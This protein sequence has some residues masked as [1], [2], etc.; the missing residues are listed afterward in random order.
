A[1]PGDCAYNRLHARFHPRVRDF[2]ESFGYYD[3]FLFD[4]DGNLVYSVFK[5]TD[6]ATNFLSGAYRDTKFA[7]VFRL[8][9]EATAPGEVLIRDFEPYDPSYGAPA[10]FIGSPVFRGHEKIGVAVFQMPVDQINDIMA[11]VSGLGETGETYL[12]GDDHLMR[13]DSRFAA[14]STILVQ[15]IDTE[16]SK[17]ALSGESGM[18]QQRDYRGIDVL[19]SYGPLQIAGLDWAMLAEVDMAEITAPAVALRNRIVAI[20]VGLAVV[21]GILT[22]FFLNRIVINPVRKLAEGTRRVERGEYTTRVH[23]GSTDE[24]GELAL[25]FNHMTASIRRDTDA[26]RKLTRAVEQSSSIVLITDPQGQIE[27]VNPKFTEVTGYT[28]QEAIG[29]NPRMLKSGKH[30]P[31]VYA[32]LWGALTSGREFHGEFQ[33]RKKDGS[34]YW[35]SVSMSPIRGVDATTT[36]FLA[37]QDDITDRKAA[38]EELHRA[39]AEA[40]AANRAKSQFLANMSHE[41]RTP[42]NAIIGYSEMLAEEAED[43]GEDALIS[44][45]NKIHGAGKHLLTLINEI[46]DLSKIE[47][48]KMELFLEE[49]DVAEMVNEVIATVTPL[50][51]KNANTLETN[52]AEDAGQ[53]RADLTKIRQSL[54]NLISNAS[55]FT[56]EGTIRVEVQRAPDNGHLMFKVADSG[57]GMNEQQLGKLFQAFS[58]ADASTTRKYGGTGLGLVIT[59]RFCDMMGGSIDV[60][61]QPGQGT[62]FTITLPAE[63]AEPQAPEPAAAAVEAEVRA[64]AT[65]PVAEVAADARLVLVIDDDPNVQD[66]MSRTLAKEGFRVE[67][68]SDGAEGLEAARRLQPDLITLDVMMSGLDGWAVLKELKDDSKTQDIP[69]IMLTMIDEKNLGY[70]LGAAEYLT[71]PVDRQRLA[72]VLSK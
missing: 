1:A 28:A 5:E 62:C 48:G 66:L 19:S 16:A 17:L 36:H 63:V 51:E 42:L 11:D 10:S 27:Y 57:I 45:L 41:L 69:V 23:I 21:V 20:G 33:N 40:E 53:M 32:K 3:I 46:L 37:I 30:P 61:S 64:A 18:M 59:K 71:K 44:D 26:L 65:R 31:E 49:F 55:K 56:K 58:Q 72:K 8:A 60:E 12:V 9:R 54:F 34:L 67:L 70:A 24:L 52:I 43:L 14:D 2:L 35:A 6:F 7:E 25:A 29:Q 50:V 15:Q 13:S 38:E 68:A 47:A 4:V 22:V 39:R